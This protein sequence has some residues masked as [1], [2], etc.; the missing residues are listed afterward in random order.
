MKRYLNQLML[1]LGMCCCISCSDSG[2]VDEEQVEE[3]SVEAQINEWVYDQMQDYYLWYDKLPE[4]K[5]LSFDQEPSTFFYGLLVD[6]DG[7]N[8]ARYS[9]IEYDESLLRSSSDGELSY[10]FEYRL[11]R[12][13]GTS[14]LIAQILYVQKE[15]PADKAGLKRGDLI[16]TVNGKAITASNYKSYLEEPQSEAEFLLGR[17]T[18]EEYFTET[19][20]VHI[21]AP[22]A[23]ADNAVYMDTVITVQ[24]RRIGY[25]MYNSFDEDYDEELCTAFR[26][27]AS[28]SIDDFVLDLRYNHGGNV[29]CAQLLATMLAP[30]SA[31]GKEFIYLKYNDKIN[32][33][34]DLLFDRRI[35]SKG[36]NLGLDRLYVI[37]SDETAS[38]SEAVINGLKPYFGSS[39]IQVGDYTFG[40]NV[41]QVLLT[42]DKWSSLKLWPTAF[43]VYNSEDFGAYESGLAPDYE[44]VET[45]LIGEFATSDDPLFMAVLSAMGLDDESASSLRSSAAHFETVYNSVSRKYPVMYVRSER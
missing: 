41:G 7:K 6:G 27:F 22:S 4:E 43:Y 30:Q 37:T 24:N 15:S 28:S 44:Y 12:I 1:I 45:L 38:S 34:T 39:L 2:V 10:G 23:V 9:R 21:D 33:R 14:E 8:G 3:L 29:D 13:V 19:N 11:I 25:L 36:A 42:D 40:K 35:I 17:M 32:E 31:L 18:S 16:I 5:S 20:T 26:K